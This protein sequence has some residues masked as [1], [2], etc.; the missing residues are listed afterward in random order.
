MA[1]YKEFGTLLSD[2]QLDDIGGTAPGDDCG[3]LEGEFPR[4]GKCCSKSTS[5][6]GTV[7]QEICPCCSIWSS[8]PDGTSLAVSYILECTLYGYGKRIKE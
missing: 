5:I 6:S 2:K 4:I 1:D 8:L 7:Y 3:V